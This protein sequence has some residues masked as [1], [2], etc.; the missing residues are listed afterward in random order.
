MTHSVLGDRGESQQNS[1]FWDI[2]TSSE[3][4]LESVQQRIAHRKSQVKSRATLNMLHGLERD[5][6]GTGVGND[7]DGGDDSCQWYDY[8]TNSYV[9][10]VSYNDSI[11]AS[12]HELRDAAKYNSMN[13]SHMSNSLLNRPSTS[14]GTGTATA[15]G[16]ASNI[17]NSLLRLSPVRGV[18][19]GTDGHGNGDINTIQTPDGML[20]PNTHTSGMD[21]SMNQWSN[22]PQSMTKLMHVANIYKNSHAYK[23]YCHS[24]TKTSTRTGTGT[25]SNSNSN[26][27]PIPNDRQDRHAGRD[28][29]DS[30]DTSSVWN[31]NESN[32]SAS[33]SSTASPN[34]TSTSFCLQLKHESLIDDAFTLAAI[35]ANN[36]MLNA[37]VTAT[38]T[39]AA[40]GTTNHNDKNINKSILKLH[41]STPTSTSISISIAPPLSEY[42]QATRF[43]SMCS[44]AIKKLRYNVHIRKASRIVYKHVYYNKLLQSSLR[45]WEEVYRDKLLGYGVTAELRSRKLLQSTFSNWKQSSVGRFVVLT[46]Q[47]HILTHISDIASKNL[48]KTVIRN[49]LNTSIPS[50]T[51]T[52]P[53]L[54]AI[55]ARERKKELYLEVPFKRWKAHFDY[56][57]R[58][59]RL[60]RLEL[61]LNMEIS[62]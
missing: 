22:Q 46:A 1:T 32:T 38:A 35:T 57:E 17:N 47:V 14:T 2:D 28:G 60:T 26:T 27:T 42:Q 5:R 44:I 41:Q 29:R 19:M 7:T 31:L 45:N 48:S 43:L 52:L 21:T 8:V 33:A 15:T 59:S 16:T 4:E 40:T 24:A 13:L 11:L 12:I 10:D 62:L 51:A 39:G 50:V 34:S 54:M 18:H 37:S 9:H 20:T 25:G 23:N 61:F 49:K 30:L 36:T 55:S 58:Y 53:Y 3:E 6:S 56:Y